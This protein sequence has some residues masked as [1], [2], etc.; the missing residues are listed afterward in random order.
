MPSRRA[1]PG[2]VVDGMVDRD[3]REWSI[4]HVG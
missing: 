4:I 3:I 2:D 1:R